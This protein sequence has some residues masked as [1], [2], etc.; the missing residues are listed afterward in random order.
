MSGERRIHVMRAVAPARIVAEQDCAARSSRS[1][2]RIAR[3]PVQGETVK[4]D[5]IAGR[6]RPAQEP[7]VSPVSGDVRHRLERTAR[8]LGQLQNA[9][10]PAAPM[11]RAHHH[12]EPRAVRDRIEGKPDIAELIAVDVETRLILMPGG[13]AGS[14]GILDEDVVGV[15]GS[16]AGSRASAPRSPAPALVREIGEAPGSDPRSDSRGN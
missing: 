9:L 10:E 7:V 13:N 1:T 3:S 14:A 6:H 5:A 11:V 2:G 15:E 12:L 8:I 4:C 16:P